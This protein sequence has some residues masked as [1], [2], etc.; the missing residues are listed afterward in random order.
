MTQ[1]HGGWPQRAEAVVGLRVSGDKP[2]P[3]ATQ[4]AE[5]E[6]KSGTGLETSILQQHHGRNQQT[7]DGV[8][9]GPGQTAG[10]VKLNGATRYSDSS[11]VLVLNVYLIFVL[12]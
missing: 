11:L 4:G 7:W 6:T 3:G 10:T 5:L 12:Q 2:G 1:S 8:K 9:C